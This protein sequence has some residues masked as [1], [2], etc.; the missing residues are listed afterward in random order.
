MTYTTLPPNARTGFAQ[1]LA[2]DLELDAW[3][4]EH[5]DL[6]RAVVDRLAQWALPLTAD[7]YA[8]QIA[9]RL[10]AVRSIG[11]ERAAAALGLYPG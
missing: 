6:A 7:E 11:P 8:Q 4:K 9:R 3:C 5:P 1:A 10:T 2:S